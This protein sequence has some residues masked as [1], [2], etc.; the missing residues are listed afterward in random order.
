MATEDEVLM[1]ENGSEIRKYDCS[2]N[3]FINKFGLPMGFFQQLP[4]LRKYPF[5]TCSGTEGI[6]II[7]LADDHSETLINAESACAWGQN[8]HTITKESYGI[9]L[10][11]TQSRSLEKHNNDL[12]LEWI[13]MDFKNDFLEF[14]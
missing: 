5:V 13:M 4:N 9:Q 6:T 8:A 11:F 12:R 1:Y 7:H 2:P 10:N 3:R 14:L